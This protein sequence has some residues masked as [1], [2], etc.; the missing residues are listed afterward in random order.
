M[1]SYTWNEANMLSETP[2]RMG[3]VP[4]IHL[5][6]AKSFMEQAIFGLA[7]VSPRSGDICMPDK[8]VFGSITRHIIS[9]QSLWFQLC[10]SYSGLGFYGWKM[11]LIWRWCFQMY[12]WGN[13]FQMQALLLKQRQVEVLQKLLNLLME[14]IYISSLTRIVKSFR[15]AY[16]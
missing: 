10:T 15:N 14:K 13:P 16:L 11:H 7:W 4:S 9:K 3:W 5:F 8:N 2:Q 1:I 6:C 12:T